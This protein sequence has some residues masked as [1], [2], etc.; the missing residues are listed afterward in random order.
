V[1]NRTSAVKGRA[2]GYTR[3]VPENPKIVLH[4]KRFNVEMRAVPSRDGGSEQREVVI[5]PGAVVVL[6]RNRRFSIDQSLW[7]LPA[8]TR[9]PG[10]APALCAAREVEEETGYRA[11]KLEP[12]LDF[13]T[14][15]GISNE[16][17]HAFLATDLSQTQ[18]QLDDT[19][20]IEVHP[21]TQERL[22]QMIF[23]REIVDAKTLATFLFFRA[24]V[25]SRNAPAGA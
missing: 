24:R 15:P 11:G 19:E 2:P 5:H 22:L 17:M 23:D 12:L 16:L 7:E 6:I 20:Q 14:A 21:V 25:E 8:G 18:Q 1:T 13:Y 10:E 9:E 3:L 4:G